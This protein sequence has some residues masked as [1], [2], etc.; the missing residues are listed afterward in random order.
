MA[1]KITADDLIAS[2]V[3]KEFQ[4]L[5]KEIAASVEVMSKAA[6]SSIEL[7]KALKG[8]SVSNE[9]ISDS[10]KKVKE[11][12][13]KLTDAE[14]QL[15]QNEKLQATLIDKSAGYIAKLRAENKL[16]YDQKK[17]LVKTDKDYY[18]QISALNDKI[19]RNGKELATLHSAAQK[20]V[21]GISTLK[22]KV[23]GLIGV[24]AAGGLVISTFKKV[25]GAT[26]ESEDKFERAMTQ[27][28]TA[29][30]LFFKSL[31]S[32]D[33]SNFGE[34]LDEVIK[35]AG[36]YFDIMDKLEDRTRSLG[37]QEAKRNIEQQKLLITMKD[38]TKSNDE[39]IGA[40]NKLE[41]I[42]KD[43]AKERVDITKKAY[44][45]Q[46]TMV[47]KMTGLHESR[48]KKY[49]E[50]YN[51]VNAVVEVGN[52]YNDLVAKRDELQEISNSTLRASNQYGMVNA[53]VN[54]LNT[55]KIK[56][57]NDEIAAMGYNAKVAGIIASKYN[58]QTKAEYDDL[59]NK[60]KAYYGAVSSADEN[61]QRAYARRS[62][63]T[64]EISKKESDAAAKRMKENDERIKKE[65][66][67]NKSIAKMREDLNLQIRTIPTGDMDAAESPMSKWYA[68][69]YDNYVSQ[70]EA[71]DEE[72]VKSDEA[73]HAKMM[74]N[75]EELAQVRQEKVSLM[76]D[77]LNSMG[78]LAN[79]IYDAELQKV[80]LNKERE[81]AAAGDNAKKKE[82]INKEYAIKEAAIKRKQATVDKVM[83]LFNI[84]M[85]TAMG[86]T[87]AL[88]KVVT[89]PLVPYI[90]ANG[91]IQAA[92]VAA[93]P[94]PKFAKGVR[95]FEGG[96][97]EVGEAGA[98][99]LR[100][101]D[102][103]IFL[104]PDKATRMALPK[105]TDVFTHNE[106]KQML[107]QGVSMDKFDELIKEQRET[108]K[109]LSRKSGKQLNITPRGWVETDTMVS[110]R[111]TYIDKYFRI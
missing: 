102:G 69:F 44:D 80:E 87:S 39:R 71:A 62:S 23:M 5:N 106:T 97:A 42:E 20:N 41:S 108:R 93:K 86:V 58:S 45:A 9:K 77:S 57:L 65:D 30:D 70:A 61:L 105:G 89:I 104:S 43:L 82:K 84:A 60:A 111:K 78:E 16:L 83:A 52:K 19:N 37:V 79:N 2:N 54:S 48:I 96:F 103:N 63:L 88:S 27:A 107:S 59:G 49:I 75:A 47:S 94:I 6:K 81:L 33:F 1:D 32:G 36:E 17:N 110:A 21:Y 66:E 11:E 38:Q 100:T 40:I 76:M 99:A 10:T 51:S 24:F 90:I 109:A 7:D 91:A 29:T 34:R 14:K 13:V 22:E 15:I 35:A 68:D 56:A 92:V 95:N 101:P 64:E 53:N 26:G 72:I 18:K 12:K 74:E 55:E 50:E 28:K 4:K 85:N 8:V 31:A 98:E 3:I 25:I 46:L 67:I 73:A